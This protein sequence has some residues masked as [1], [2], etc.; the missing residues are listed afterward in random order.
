MENDKVSEAVYVKVED[1]EGLYIDDKLVVE[2]NSIDLAHH[3]TGRAVYFNYRPFNE[4]D[5]NYTQNVGD[6]PEYFW[7]LQDNEAMWDEDNESTN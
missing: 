7:E 4:A 3:L 6:L 1:W 2:G 5:E